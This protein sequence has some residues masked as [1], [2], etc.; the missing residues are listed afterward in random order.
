MKGRCYFR[1]MALALLVCFGRLSAIPSIP[2]IAEQH[3]AQ[4]SW[5][6]RT[7][8][9]VP[10]WHYWPGIAA[11]AAGAA[12]G[13]S[14]QQ[15]LDEILKLSDNGI[16]VADDIKRAVYLRN[17]GT[18][19]AL[20][21]PLLLAGGY[22]AKQ[23]SNYLHG[24]K[25]VEPTQSGYYAPG[26]MAMAVPPLY[27]AAGNKVTPETAPAFFAMSAAGPA[28]YGLGHLA[29]QYVNQPTVPSIPEVEEPQNTHFLNKLVTPAVGTAAALA[30]LYG[31][32]QYLPYLEKNLSWDEYSRA[33]DALNALTNFS[34]QNDKRSLR[35]S[36]AAIALGVLA[37]VVIASRL[38]LLKP[39]V[40]RILRTN[41][42]KRVIWPAHW[43]ARIR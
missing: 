6:D 13:L 8:H 26:I 17:V 37:E 1:T 25:N 18:A 28:L 22:G 33:L 40:N 39:I 4:Q 34:A 16:W 41:L 27:L 42:A 38:G 43:S 29:H 2:L 24:A 36:D 19:G 12:V 9:Y 31:L 7:K 10:S 21:A 35:M 23:L 11:G 5:Y 30:S 15:F 20:S 32:S 14:G 3:P